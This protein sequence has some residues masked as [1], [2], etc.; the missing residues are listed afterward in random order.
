MENGVGLRT[1]LK[2]NSTR[3]IEDKLALIKQ[4]QQQTDDNSSVSGSSSDEDASVSIKYRV[5]A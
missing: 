2:R 4:M 5:R 3:V 1:V